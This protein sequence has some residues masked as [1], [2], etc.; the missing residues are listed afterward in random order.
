MEKTTVKAEINFEKHVG[1][2]I[3]QAGINFEKKVKKRTDEAGSD[4]EK[5]VEKTT[6]EDEINCEEHDRGQ[7]DIQIQS[8]D[9]DCVAGSLRIVVSKMPIVNRRGRPK[10]R[11]ATACML[12]MKNRGH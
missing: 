2:T 6:V 1:K 10:Q 3:A 9:P 7:Q 12:S 4:L 8:T 11:A 5:D